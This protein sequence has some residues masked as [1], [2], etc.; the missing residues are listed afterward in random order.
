[1]KERIL[2]EEN[3][4]L[5]HSAVER[6][7][8][9]V[10]AVSGLIL[11]FS[12]FGEFPMYKRYMVTQIPGF[13]WTADFWINLK[14]H[15]IAA[16]VFTGAAVFHVTYHGMLGHQG[17]LPRKGDGKASMKTVL[18]FIGIGEEPPSD[19]YLPEQRL[20][21][22]YIAAVS[23]ILILTGLI[24]VIK[25]LPFVYLPP[26][27]I[28]VATLTHTAATFLFLFGVIAHLAALALK[29]NWPLIKP[30]FTG[31]ADL[32]YI[33]HRHSI[34]YNELIK[35]L[36]PEVEKVK[37]EKEIAADQRR[38][39]AVGEAVRETVI[40]EP[41]TGEEPALEAKAEPPEAAEKSE[42]DK[43]VTS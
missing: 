21:Y 19:K 34:W 28:T 38:A 25:N 1:M 6:A 9:W 26:A 37:E 27:V 15:Y 14:I 31:K 42:D 22:A 39:E 32:D 23:L 4:V 13:S 43:P 3:A 36:P 5:R 33:R 2:K 8:H 17:L 35:D 16:I 10:I 41:Q 20:A 18:S 12:G 7:E 11:L 40:E 30:M 24:K 29:V